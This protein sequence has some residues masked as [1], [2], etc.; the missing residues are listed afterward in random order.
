MM[1]SQKV[2]APVKPMSN[3]SAIIRK[4]WIPAFAGMTGYRNFWLF[5]RTS[6]LSDTISEHK[7]KPGREKFPAGFFE[8]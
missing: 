7:K 4:H 8:L 3:L 2:V 6:G 5:T 1:V